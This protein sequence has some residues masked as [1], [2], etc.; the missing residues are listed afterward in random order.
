MHEKG[1]R[2]LIRE[3]EQNAVRLWVENGQ[4]R[5]KAPK[6]E[7]PETL[8]AALR[9]RRD[10]LIGELSTPVFRKSG[11]T[12]DLVRYP[13]FWQ[14]FWEET[15]AN[16]ALANAIHLA[17]KLSGEIDLERID[18]ALGRL[19]SRYDLLRSRVELENGVPCLRFEQHQVMP[20]DILDV[21]DSA[22]AVPIKTLIEQA[23]YAPFENGRLHRARVIKIS[24]N[25]YVVVI[26]IHHF[27][28]DPVSS[29]ILANE[30]IASLHN[31]QGAQSLTDARPLQYSD[32]LLGMS[33]WLSGE[34]LKYRLAYWTEK[35]RGA[36]PVRFPLVHATP[37]AGLAC[38]SIHIDEALRASAARA[39]AVSG[40]PFALVLLAAKFAA[41]A[42]TLQSRDLVT[43]MIHH[44]R[45]DPA[46]R[47]LVGFTLNCFPVRVSVPPEMAYGELL[48]SVKDTYFLARD[49]QV[50]WGLLMRSLGENGVSGVAPIFNYIP[51]LRA[52]QNVLSAFHHT[53]SLEVDH[54]DVEGLAETN[55]VAWKSHEFQVVDFG[56]D[57]LVSVKYMPSRHAAAAVEGFARSFCFCLEMIAQEPTRLIGSATPVT[58]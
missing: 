27:V 45:D 11:C 49:Y 48:A 13:H 10:D 6:G 3:A 14:D 37:E 38:V 19:I 28:A 23:I 1:V 12:P 25:E 42:H 44:G 8:R 32:Y 26:V 41:L 40:V 30:L 35:M 5:Y 33:E 2:M 9:S 24:D 15:Q 43:I 53:A 51:Q 46:L 4:L 18:S 29:G 7:I 56:S 20:I 50:P 55:S 57:M 17:I 54:I 34:G 16:L 21:S 31:E 22:A 39:A 58:A 36:P 47:E 52:E